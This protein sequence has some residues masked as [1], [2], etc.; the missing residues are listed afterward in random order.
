M[1][2]ITYIYFLHKGDNIPFY[3]GKSV[4]PEGR[5]SLHKKR[6]GEIKMEFI[7]IVPTSEWLFWEKWY[8]GLFKS[9]GFILENKNVGGGGTSYHSEE[10]KLKMTKPKP[11]GFGA[12]VTLRLTGVQQSQETI[13]KRTSKT[14][15]KK[16][17]PEQKEKLRVAF[18]DRVFSEERNKKIGDTQ[19]G[20]P[21]PKSL[22]TISKLKKPILQYDKK[23]NFIQEWKSAKDASL[24]FGSDSVINGALR[25]R[26]KT[27][28]G[29]IWKYKK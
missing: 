28:Y 7:D 13:A 11:K 14:K 21:Q 9:W 29:F 19:R 5:I 22:E 24:I 23:G 4:Y 15:G 26:I 17:T 6:F 12:Q 1:Q 20:V 2:E 8:I 16:R 27:A 10:T 25:G 3:V 18:K